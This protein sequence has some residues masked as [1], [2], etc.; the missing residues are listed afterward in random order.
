MT[1]Q[2]LEAVRRVMVKYQWHSESQIEVARYVAP[3]LKAKSEVGVG[4]IYSATTTSI[5]MLWN[6]NLSTIPF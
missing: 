3:S 6:N 4:L 2:M 1:V 5:S